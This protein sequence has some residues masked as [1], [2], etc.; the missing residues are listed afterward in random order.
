MFHR[1]YK[2]KPQC[3]EMLETCVHQ[4]E[5]ID[6]YVTQERIILLDTQVISFLFNLLC[7]LL[8]A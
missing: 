5:G 2:F 3:Y 6:M 4:T 1:E 8:Q 7:Q